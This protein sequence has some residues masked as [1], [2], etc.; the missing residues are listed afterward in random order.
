SHS[1]CPSFSSLRSSDLLNVFGQRNRV[2][3]IFLNEHVGNR[4]RPCT[5]IASVFHKHGDRNF[6]VL[7]GG[8]SKENGMVFT[9]GILRSTRFSRSEEHTSELQSRENLV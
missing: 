3:D 1:Q 7:A 8:E 2:I 9:V 6:R 4:T 5:T